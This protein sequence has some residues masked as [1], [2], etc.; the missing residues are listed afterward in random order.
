M[1]KKSSGRSC[2][3]F[4]SCSGALEIAEAGYC[5]GTF[6]APDITSGTFKDKPLQCKGLPLSD[7]TNGQ[8]QCYHPRVHRTPIL[9]PAAEGLKN[10]EMCV[11][12]TACG[13]PAVAPSIAVRVNE[14]F[15]TCLIG[16]DAVSVATGSLNNVLAELEA[17]AQQ[18]TSRPLLDGNFHSRYHFVERIEEQTITAKGNYFDTVAVSLPTEQF[19]IDKDL[20][21]VSGTFS[22]LVSIWGDATSIVSKIQ[23]ATDMQ[24][25]FKALV[26]QFSA[27]GSASLTL[28]M[29]VNALTKGA[30]PDVYATLAEANM[31]VT[32]M[33]QDELGIAKG[34]YAFAK[35]S[36]AIKSTISSLLK[37]IVT[38]FAGVLD[39]LFG[40]GTASAI[41]ANAKPDA[42]TNTVIATANAEMSGF[43]LKVPVLGAVGGVLEAECKVKYATGD[44]SC[45]FDYTEPK[46]FNGVI[47]AAGWVVTEAENFFE[48]TPEGK[49]IAAIAHQIA[50]DLHL[51]EGVYWTEKAIQE[52][53]KAI[54]KGAVN[55]GS[56]VETWAKDSGVKICGLHTVTSAALCGTRIVTDAA[57]CGLNR[58]DGAKC[59]WDTIKNGNI[60]GWNVCIGWCPHGNSPKS[61]KQAK[62]CEEVK[63]CTID[64]S[65]DVPIDCP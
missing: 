17:W 22:R 31:F 53:A 55:L 59:G 12:F 60:C 7:S 20:F 39:Q 49:V 65:C 27:L 16:N 29:K 47:Q 23:A 57:A 14:P 52:T 26:S 5:L 4:L 19:G 64:L 35:Q 46:W 63:T 34:F 8:F 56:A 54:E 21:G 30:F 1:D 44:F 10:I 41:T 50:D 18:R 36:N 13:N 33:E 32:T 38:N 2:Q 42:S 62:S 45:K 51:E 61:C 3:Q 43:M 28:T 6:D 58:T 40:S 11:A 9:C 37:S 48:N 15:V 25:T 24:S